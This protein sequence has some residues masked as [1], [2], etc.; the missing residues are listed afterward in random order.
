[1]IYDFDKIID[2][3]GTECVKYDLR[4]TVF[5][6]A[7]V[8]PMWVADMDFPTA[9]FIREAIIER[10]KGDVYGYT[11][12]EDAYFESIVNWLQRHHQWE[13]KKEW[14]SFTPGIVN[15]FNL[16]VMGLTKEGDE[17]I[18]QPPVY[19]P[20]FFAVNNHNRKLVENPLIDTEDGYVMDFDLLEQQ[21][22][23]AKMLI[24]SNPH[25]PVGRAW[26]KEELMRLGE[27]C[28]KNNVLVFSD[29][30]HCDLVMPGFKH[31]PFASLSEEFAQNSIT[32]HAASKTFNL[33]GLAT[34]TVIIPNEDLRK[35]YCDFV[36]STEADMGN[37]F[38]K[39]A[40]KAAME[41]G[42]EWHSQ[43]INYIKGNIDFLDDYLQKHIP[44]LSFIRPQASYL[45]FLDCRALGLSQEALVS[46][47]IDKAH[48]A[49]NDGSMFG[50]EGEGFMRLN[51]G[52]PRAVLAQALKQLAD[53]LK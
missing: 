46:L 16:A 11:F 49:L 37:V 53:A 24:L 40:T 19:H 48:L 26:K 44:Q 15:A 9:D 7:D 27:I 5:G 6:K 2:R 50:V 21:A 12:R 30:I 18:I 31:I 34:S 28:M 1:M 33:A 36:H 38:G 20:F 17:I 14:M 22:K 32:A 51:V 39:I 43:L 4:E 35:K 52:C 29:E 13:T 23:T 8:I 42:D 45:V 10:A 41:K 47:F 25:N 3:T